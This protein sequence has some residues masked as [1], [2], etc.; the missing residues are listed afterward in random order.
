MMLE[1][2]RGSKASM[3]LWVLAKQLRFMG[4]DE[5][6][7]LVVNKVRMKALAATARPIEVNELLEFFG[8][9]QVQN[10]WK[11][12]RERLAKL[13]KVFKTDLELNSFLL[14]FFREEVMQRDAYQCFICANPLSPLSATLHHIFWD[15]GV[16]FNVPSNLVTFCGGCHLNIGCGEVS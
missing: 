1:A 16:F 5:L 11:I 3:L 9:E 10:E 7:E 14:S 6:K 8:L 2:P 12:W 13:G 4:V 15:K